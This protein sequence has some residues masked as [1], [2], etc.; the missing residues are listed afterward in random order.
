MIRDLHIDVTI[1]NVYVTDSDYSRIVKFYPEM[2]LVN[3]SW[4]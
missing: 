1:N 2:A 4:C 3:S